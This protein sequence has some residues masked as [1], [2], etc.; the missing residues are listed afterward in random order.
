MTYREEMVER[1]HRLREWTREHELSIGLTTLVILALLAYLMPDMAI[2]VGP[3][4]S[5][6]LWRRFDGG[7]VT[8]ADDGRPFIGRIGADRAGNPIGVREHIDDRHREVRRLGYQVWP[9]GEGL[10]FIWPW[11]RMYLYDIR[12]HQI[13]HTYDVLT[14]DGLDVKAEVTIRWKP[15][16]ADLGKLHRDIGPH[17]VETLIIPLVGA[18]VREEIAHY[19][20]DA[21]YSPTRLVIQEAVRAKTKQALMS[22]FYPEIRRES[23]I[24]VEDVLIRNVELPREVRQAIQDKVVQK[25][26]AESFK[27]RL[28]RERQEAERKAIEAQGIQR[29]QAAIN[30]TISEGYLRWKGI[31]ATLELAKSQNAKIV[32]IGSGKDGM[33]IILGGMDGVQTPGAARPVITPP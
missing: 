31:D 26:I 19:T 20:P 25:H 21:L 23:Y 24:L 7:T 8:I 18:Y 1:W 14:N 32:V 5:G 3:G 11:N 22:R 10:H 30:S 16:E 2:T 15:I 28:D 29:F 9:Y 12:L 13:S 17:Y 4:Q 27:Y 33:P 6:V